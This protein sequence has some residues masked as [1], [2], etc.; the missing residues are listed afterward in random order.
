MLRAFLARRGSILAPLAPGWRRELAAI[1]QTRRLAPLLMDD[2]A[3]LQILLCVRAVRHLDGEMAEAGV[4]K[5]GSARLI[6]EAKGEVPLHLFD[7]FETLQSANAP[8][9]TGGAELRAHF[10]AV[11]GARIQV[12]RLLAHYGGVHLHPGVFPTSAAGLE[13]LKFSFIHLDLDLTESTRAALEFFHPRLMVGGIL[14][15]DDYNDAAVR[16]VFATYFRDFRDTL[17]ELPWGQVMIVKQ[18]R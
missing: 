15:G 5:G 17:I 7:V 6:C 10:G 3:A 12:E 2:A 9:S 14:I 8:A 11:H 16:D 1:R 18:A 13:D 4:L